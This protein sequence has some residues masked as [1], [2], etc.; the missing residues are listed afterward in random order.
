MKDVSA[1]VNPLNDPERLSSLA[2]T[3]LL[4]SPPEPYFDR[5]TRLVCKLVGTQTA[6]LSLVS[7]DRQFFKSA[8]GF[9]GPAADARETPLSHSFCKYVVSTGRPFAVTDAS[10]IAELSDHGAVVDL[11]VISYLGVPIR[12]PDGLVLGSLCALSG[13]A[14]SWTDDDLATMQDLAAILEDDIALRGQAQASRQLAE[15]NAILAREYHHRV[16]NVLAVSSSLVRLAGRDAH[17]VSDLIAKASDRLTA[18]SEAHSQ[19]LADAE[20]VDLEQLSIK[21]LLPYCIDGQQ[22]NVQGPAVALV[23]SQITPICFFLH[24]LSTNSSKYGAFKRNGKVTLRWTLNNGMVQVDWVEQ[25]TDAMQRSPEGFGS[26][27]IESA[28]RQLRGTS[29]TTWSEDGLTGSLDFPLAS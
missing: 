27:L 21:L 29:T 3:A 2:K 25:L 11:G 23:H 22:P 7:D 12:A 24:E 9:S 26:K 14:K 8:C 17:S 5:V 13:D 6:L 19:L 20:A 28:A 1:I 10:K 15:D 18:L 16:K 4:D